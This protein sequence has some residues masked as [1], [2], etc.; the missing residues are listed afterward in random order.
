MT[1][2]ILGRSSRLDKREGREFPPQADRPRHN[3][4]RGLEEILNPFF[5]IIFL[6]LNNQLSFRFFWVFFEK[7]N[8]FIFHS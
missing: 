3:K 7:A 6:I 8:R 2:H 1:D 5:F 4:I